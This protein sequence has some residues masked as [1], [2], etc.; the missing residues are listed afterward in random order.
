M[1]RPLGRFRDEP[2][3]LIHVRRSHACPSA[4]EY[5]GLSQSTL[6]KLRMRGDGPVYSKAG[7]RVIVY[8]KADLD[9]WLVARKRRSTS[10]PDPLE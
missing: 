5:V 2:K 10:E 6:A 4:A 9:A 7:P 8:D 3:E 1:H